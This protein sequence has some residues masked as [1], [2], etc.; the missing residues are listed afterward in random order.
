MSGEFAGTLDQHVRIERRAATRDDLGGADGA[1]TTQATLWA[2]IAPLA[3]APWGLGDRPAASL[4]WVATLRL[5]ADVRAGDRLQWRGRLFAIRAAEADP[6]TPD[7]LTLM[8][9]EDR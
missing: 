5:G 2:A 6:A 7:R 4:R 9:E 1:W 8:L 3:S